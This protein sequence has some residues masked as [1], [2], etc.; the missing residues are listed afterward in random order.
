MISLFG[1]SGN[2]FQ[3]F[4]ASV[5]IFNLANPIFEAFGLYSY[6]I[7]N[8]MLLGDGITVPISNEV[9]NKTYI[10]MCCFLGGSSIGWILSL[11]SSYPTRSKI[12][13]VNIK[14]NLSFSCRKLISYIFYTTFILVVV[15]SILLLNYSRIYG[16]IDV[17]HLHETDLNIPIILSLFELLYK[18]VGSIFIFYSVNQKD[19]VIRSVVFLIPFWI[20]FFA[21]S[22]G[23]A[24]AISLAL[25]LIYTNHYRFISIFKYIKYFLILFILG[26]LMGSYRWMSSPDLSILISNFIDLSS[27]HFFGNASSLAILSYTIVLQD[28]FFNSTPFVFGY[29]DAI[30]SFAPNYTIEG[31]MH[32]NYLAQHITYLLNPEKLLRGSTIGTSQ[33][34]EFYE[35]VGGSLYLFGVVSALYIFA[36]QFLLRI[37][38][39]NPI[40]FYLGLT[41]FEFFILSPRGSVFKF[42]NKESL[43]LILIAVIF[44]LFFKFTRMKVASKNKL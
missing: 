22:R 40:L 31:I 2:I 5:F 41:Y 4:L 44:Y 37:I 14:F 20:L 19:F 17:I 25:V 12:S 38:F 36:S 21:G 16:Y 27:F 35:L 15:K 29:L 1:R 33:A 28:Q 43:V 26:V 42:I 23:E 34:A 8:L 6:P 9:L 39:V 13:N 7:D 32:K 18:L 3:I 30:F 11:F 24:I 10:I